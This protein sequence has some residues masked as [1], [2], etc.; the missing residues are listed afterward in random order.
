MAAMSPTF[1]VVSDPFT[2]GIICRK[3]RQIIQR[4]GFSDQ[5]FET[6][7]QMLLTQVIQAMPSFNAEIA[8]PNVFITTVVERYV[9]T[10]LT[11]RSAIK[12]GPS[13]VQS[14]NA[15]VAV[16]HDAPTQLQNTLEETTRDA[17]L[18]I[19]RRPASNHSDLVADMAVVISTFPE[20]WQRMLELGKS[21]SI[22]QISER[23]NVPRSTLRHWMKRV[24]AK[25]E[26]E[27]LREYLA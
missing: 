18:Q 14:L 16:P 22:V 12:R 25:F 15:L 17:R 11:R 1:D 19:E 8:H 2:R 6:L 5:D 7:E 23:M 13:R 21:L 27:G 3:V 26:A 10:I 20:P 24:K 9:R 4:P